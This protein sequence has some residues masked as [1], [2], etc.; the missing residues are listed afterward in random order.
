V[1]NHR[2]ANYSIQS[3]E[4]RRLLAAGD[5][6]LNFGAAGFV[7]GSGGPINK[8]V[9][10]AAGVFVLAQ[11]DTGPNSDIDIVKILPNGQPDPSF[12]VNGEVVFGPT[13]AQDT[14]ID[15][16]VSGTQIVVLGRRFDPQQPLDEVFIARL[17]PD[18]SPDTSF[19][20]DG[21]V[22]ISTNPN[23]DFE[24][25]TADALGNVYVGGS[26][27]GLLLLRKFGND[28][29]IDPGFG[30]SG[31]LQF[32]AATGSSF[33]ELFV[34]GGTILAGGASFTDAFVYSR[35]SGDGSATGGFGAGGI[36]TVSAF[37]P[38]TS[39]RVDSLS[40]IVLM[41]FQATG[42]A[43]ARLL[44]DGS[45]DTAFGAGGQ[46]ALGA[47]QF[48]ELDIGPADDVYVAGE[49]GNSFIVR[50]LLGVNGSIDTTYGSGGDATAPIPAAVALP[51]VTTVIVFADGS[52][53]VGGGDVEAGDSFFL[54]RLLGDAAQFATFDGRTGVLTIT[55]TP[56]ADVLTVNVPDGFNLV[57]QLGPDQQIFPIAS[58]VQYIIDVGGGA[59]IVT[60]GPTVGVGGS[61]LLGG[62]NNNFNAASTAAVTIVGGGG[63]DTIF[64]GAGSDFIQGNGGSD[65]INAGAGDD[66]VDTGSGGD[67]ASGDDGN[68]SLTGGDGADN[69]A[70]GPGNDILFG[71]LGPDTL[72]GG[73]GNDAIFGEGGDDQIIGEAGNDTL[74]GADGVDTIDGQAGADNIFAG[75]AGG[76]ANGGTGNDSIFGGGGNDQLLG[77]AGDDTIDGVGGADSIFGGTE[78]D[79]IDTGSG[80][81]LAD[82]NE[83]NDT[84]NGGDG[85]DQLIGGRG[86]DLLAGRAGNDTLIGAENDDVL[87]GMEG[88]DSIIGAGGNDLLRG[89][90]GNDE[91][92]GSN[93]SDT[94]D[95]GGGADRL[96]GGDQP[97][98]LMGADGF[99]T[100]DGQL[101]N[102]FVSGGA[103]NDLLISDDGTT[104]QLN[105]DAG[106]DIARGDIDEDYTLVEYLYRFVD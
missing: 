88:D 89:G 20:G 23:E 103:G 57:A 68:D 94:L 13:P 63:G 72:F 49:T 37:A 87:D 54:G 39:M 90:I 44:P 27:P 58:I 16:F 38:I 52:T 46:V 51:I 102:D 35:N 91:L 84:V 62:G 6:D 80:G 33:T 4:P 34:A 101:G 28:G 69:I 64:G 45:P 92:S 32:T 8:V 5:L 42:A 14:A 83:G 59:D 50:R 29:T 53:L 31:T 65:Q 2:N 19:S 15:L 86:N 30:T 74:D 98:T 99:D 48:T 43:V 71:R 18:G 77:D 85:A 1:Q 47:T 41:G 105:G 25:V 106:L 79:L 10:S 96:F 104:D 70:G 81:D 61:V 66:T 67:F 78:N 24:S 73:D 40:R 97:D 7:T 75:P 82:G 55:G 93:G 56:A 100:L 3:L 9:N 22:V 76:F 17:N 95:G 11:T 60:I 36:A 12:G 26:A 21:A